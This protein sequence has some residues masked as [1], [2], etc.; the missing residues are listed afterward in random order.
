MSYKKSILS[1]LGL[2]Y[3]LAYAFDLPY[4]NEFVM[5]LALGLIFY[6]ND[7]VQ[8]FKDWRDS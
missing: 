2:L 6:V 3:I 5:Y 8:V 4:T 7:G 1:S